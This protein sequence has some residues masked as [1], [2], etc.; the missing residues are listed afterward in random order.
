MTGSSASLGADFRAE[1]PARND[2]LDLYL[3]G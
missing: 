2:S 1:Q 3:A